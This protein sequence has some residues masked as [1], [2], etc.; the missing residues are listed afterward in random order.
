MRLAAVDGYAQRSS[1]LEMNSGPLSTLIVFGANRMKKQAGRQRICVD[2]DG[3]GIKQHF[4]KG[5]DR[6]QAA[7]NR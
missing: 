6:K 2:M 1:A 4:P 3:V 7:F 5:R